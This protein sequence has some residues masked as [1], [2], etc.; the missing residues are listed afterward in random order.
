VAHKL[1]GDVPLWA[2][3]TMFALVALCVY[4]GL[5]SSLDNAT[6]QGLAAY[7]NLVKLAPRP[8][9]LSITLP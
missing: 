5:K 6:Q 8:A 3:S 1:R 9:S 2:V 4:M 7:A